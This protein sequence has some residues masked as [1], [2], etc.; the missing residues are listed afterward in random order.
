[1][2]HNRVFLCCIFFLAKN[3]LQAAIDIGILG[4]EKTVK[5]FLEKECSVSAETIK[6]DTPGIPVDEFKK[7][8]LVILYDTRYTLTTEENAIVKDYLKN[9]GSFIIFGRVLDTLIPKNNQGYFISWAAEWLGASNYGMKKIQHIF[10]I[11]ENPLMK[12]L[13]NSEYK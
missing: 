12:H 8:K 6:S 10:V 7:Y 5:E 11:R 13:D 4:G 9:G 2:N 3:Y 1:M